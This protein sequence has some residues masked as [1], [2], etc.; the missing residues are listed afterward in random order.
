MINK[1]LSA[2]VQAFIKE[3]DGDDPFQLSLNYSDVDGV[4]MP[5]I[6]EQISGRQKAK[7][8]LPSWYANKRVIFPPR[9]SMEQCSSEITA[10]YK[11]SLAQG[12]TFIDLTGGAGVDTWALSKVFDNG[13]YVEQN[14]ELTS[15]SKSNFKA[16]GATNITILYSTAEEFLSDLN[17][18]VD[19]IYIDP[20]RRDNN[21]N[22]VYLLADCLPDITRL[23]PE[24]RE[25]AQAVLVK[26]SPMMDIDLSISKL[27]G[28]AE[29]HVV[30]IDNDCKEV[31][32]MNSPKSSDDIVVKTKNFTKA[33]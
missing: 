28:I 14:R 9:L 26:T 18:Q 3:H 1:V 7:S 6:S 25:K 17:D 27:A 30:A 20:A 13:T 16:L 4:P 31:L 32:Y 15:I 24:L 10:N 2:E 19:F 12:K 29:V 33:R 23:L 21:K 5:L 11:A 22:R 8:K